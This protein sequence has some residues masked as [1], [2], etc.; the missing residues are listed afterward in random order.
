MCLETR[1]SGDRDLCRAIAHAWGELEVTEGWDQKL[2][3]GG[4]DKD[5][6]CSWQSFIEPLPSFCSP[7][8]LAAT[9]VHPVPV[10]G[11][12]DYLDELAGPA[13]VSPTKRQPEKAGH[14]KPRDK[15]EGCKQQ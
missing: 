7:S 11:F 3:W 10:D 13:F 5:G 2:G 15:K 12:F 8:A 9:P 14:P 1:R 4:A 6:G